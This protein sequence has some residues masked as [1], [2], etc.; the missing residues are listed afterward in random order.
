LFFVADFEAVDCVQGFELDVDAGVGEVVPAL[1]DVFVDQTLAAHAH[2]GDVLEPQ[3]Q[4]D[5]EFLGAAR[6]VGHTHVG[7]VE[8]LLGQFEAALGGG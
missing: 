2:G 5:P 4:L 1:L 8:Q 6:Q 3:E 7:H